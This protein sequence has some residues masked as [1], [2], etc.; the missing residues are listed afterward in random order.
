MWFGSSKDRSVSNT[1]LVS[2]FYEDV[3][4]ATFYL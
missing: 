1:K 2:S 4:I 3:Y